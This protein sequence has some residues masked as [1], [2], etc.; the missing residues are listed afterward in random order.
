V[1]ARP[2]TAPALSSTLEEIPVEASSAEP[3]PLLVPKRNALTEAIRAIEREAEPQPAI[4]LTNAEDGDAENEG[5]EDKSHATVVDELVLRL[6]ELA[7]H[8]SAAEWA[9]RTVQFVRAFERAE[10]ASEAAA[11]AATL[12]GDLL[13]SESWAENLSEPGLSTRVLMARH[14]VQRW[15]ALAEPLRRFAPTR[16]SNHND[17]AYSPADPR[18]A[19]LWSAIQRA[20]SHL[21]TDPQGLAWR[22]YLRIPAIQSVLQSPADQ[23]AEWPVLI[24]QAL[25]QF[26]TKDLNREHVRVLTSPPLLALR[27]A[28]ELALVEP[29]QASTFQSQ[30]LEYEQTRN[31]VPANYLAATA[32]RLLASQQ[33][34]EQQLGR[35]L[36]E[37]YRNY[38]L[39]L[40]LSQE[41][42]NRLLPAPAPKPGLVQETILGV[43]V[44]GRQTTY[45]RLSTSFATDADRLALLL[46][47]QGEIDTNTR[48]T[49]GPATLLTVGQSTFRATTSVKLSN[50]G[51][52]RTEPQVQVSAHNR[53]CDVETKFDNIPLFGSMLQHYVRSRYARSAD[54]ANFEAEWKAAAKIRQQL[55]EELSA[56]LAEGET[57]LR[58]KILNPLEGLGIRPDRYALQTTA[59]RMQMRVRLAAPHQLGSNAPRPRGLTNDWANLQVHETALNNVLEQMQ[60]SN[61]RLNPAG[62]AALFKTKLGLDKLTIELDGVDDLYFTFA[63]KDPLRLHAHEG[64]LE[65]QLNL[66]A[67]EKGPHMGAGVT[68]RA[69]YRPRQVGRGVELVRDGTPEVSIED[70]AP[71]SGFVLRAVF[72]KLF[73]PNRPLPLV[74]E[75]R[76]QKPKLRDVAII[77]TEI[78]EGW[79]G[80]AV[81]PAHLAPPTEPQTS[82]AD[83]APDPNGAPPPAAAS[84]PI[85]PIR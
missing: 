44:R 67:L 35:E 52:E 7:A 61:Q 5:D 62:L 57:E 25:L 58:E 24:R 18:E 29:F 80:M 32:H 69:F 11:I 40:S 38:N 84:R 26:Q 59:D 10:D 9:R 34:D 72:T 37:N 79:I 45:T 73:S 20:E 60:L 17:T 6:D 85:Q 41:F 27:D 30:W 3:L 51:I 2:A 8:P 70:V 50:S 68:A 46:F 49:Q 77:Q 33:P 43:P 36:E 1:S 64:R 16:L 15:L 31:S 65:I 23:R 19:R 14:A 75:S 4:L 56:Q 39:R 63:E 53:L 54:E 47:A 42:V 82:P 55:D 66:K 74:P 76:L 83:P 22:D 12:R 28:L 48:S 78:R 71:R 13:Q 81:G 21:Q